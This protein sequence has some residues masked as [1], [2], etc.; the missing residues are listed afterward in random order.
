MPESTPETPTAAG[1]QFRTTHWSVVVRAGDV[2]RTDAGP[3][4]AELCQ[5]Y[6]FPLYAFARRQGRNPADAEDLTQAFFARLLER[7]F[8]AKAEP[9]KGRFRTFLLTV[10]RRYLASEWNREHAKKRGGFQTI[11]SLDAAW[12][13]SRYGIEPGHGESADVLFE[14]QWALTLLH[15]VMR[16]L[17]SEYAQSGRT[18][19]FQH[20]EAC[21]TRDEAALPYTQIGVELGLSEAAVKM[22]MQ[23][24]RA[25]YRA[26][27]R[28]EISKTVASP[29]AV[30][31]EIRDLFAAVRS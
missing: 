6:W 20:L 3:A 1:A 8:V 30:E 26:I 17:E 21:L 22:A 2:N 9:E 16:R 19:L 10:F 23:R 13:E 11:V 28:E 5:I 12:A 31:S 18:R 29:E 27:L 7:N 24:L 25:R 14:R 4:L 15:E